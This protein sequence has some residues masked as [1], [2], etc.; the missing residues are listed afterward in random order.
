MI[1]K[2][3]LDRY[4]NFINN[5][6]NRHIPKKGTEKHHIQPR[7]VGGSDE[8]DNMIRLTLRE[9]FVAHKLLYRAYK[10]DALSRA[11]YMMS[12]RIGVKTSR[13]YEEA[14]NHFRSK[15]SNM[16]KNRLKNDPTVLENFINMVNNNWKDSA[17]IER[18][19]KRSSTN[20]KRLN[21]DIEFSEKRLKG[22]E[23]YHST[24]DSSIK[25]K[26]S[27]W[28]RQSEK[29][30]KAQYYYDKWVESGRP[31]DTTGFIRCLGGKNSTEWNKYQSFHLRFV[32]QG[33]IPNQDE[34]WIS[35]SHNFKTT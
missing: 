6:K 27:N 21:T 10:S 16:M 26:I 22:L 23:T 17:H 32:K 28:T 19:S 30:L 24:N 2:I 13:D 12:N 25:S 34:V 5:R 4:N 8:P 1:S 20:M 9:H 35:W 11:F 14:R 7:S 15:V 18:H 29:W 31:C 33:W 3:Q